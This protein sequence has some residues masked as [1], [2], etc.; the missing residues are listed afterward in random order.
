M[1][2]RDTGMPV[3][4][5]AAALGFVAEHFIRLGAFLERGLCFSLVLVVAIG[6]ILHRQAAIG[7]FYLVAVGSPRD[8]EHLVVVSF[9]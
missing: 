6:V 7:A 4:I 1:P 8:T 5:V 9:N 2:A 3:L